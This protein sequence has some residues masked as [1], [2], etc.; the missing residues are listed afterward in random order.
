MP[1]PKG[2]GQAKHGLHDVCD[3]V[4]TQD[5]LWY[6]GNVCRVFCAGPSCVQLHSDRNWPIASKQLWQCST[7]SHSQPQAASLNRRLAAETRGQGMSTQFPNFCMQGKYAGSQIRP[8][9]APDR[10]SRQP[11]A[12]R[13]APCRVLQW[14]APEAG[15][16]CQGPCRLTGN[17][18]QPLV[19]LLCH[20]RKRKPRTE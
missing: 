15:G 17:T 11:G 1:H 14:S 5:S 13:G 19:T 18:L 6:A 10:A 4:L 3:A 12:E 20:S 8:A 9:A 7:A 2:C 16:G